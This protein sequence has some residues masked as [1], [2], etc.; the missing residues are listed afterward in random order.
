MLKFPLCNKVEF[1]ERFR[2]ISLI[3]MPKFVLV[4]MM[5]YKSNFVQIRTE[6]V[7]AINGI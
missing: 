2:E 6:S 1:E 5:V 4:L 7:A 3:M